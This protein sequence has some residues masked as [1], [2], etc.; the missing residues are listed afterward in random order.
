MFKDHLTGRSGFA[1]RALVLAAA[2][3]FLSPARAGA[4]EAKYPEHPIRLVIGAGP[5]LVP[6][7]IAQKIQEQFGHN[8]FVDQQPGAGGVIAAQ[9]V[10]K[11]KP[12]GYTLLFSTATFVAIQAFRPNSTFDMSRDFEPV[13][14]VGE[15]PAVLFAHPSIGVSNLAELRAYAAKHPGELNCASSG[16]G[17]Q[18]HLGCEILRRFGGMDIVHIP[19]NGIAPAT[20]DLLAGRAQMLFGFLTNMPFVEDGKLVAIAVSSSRRASAAPNIPTGIEAGLPDLDYTTWYGLS[21]PKGTPRAI[22]DQ[23]NAELKAVLSDAF[24]QDR[25]R[26]VGFEPEPSTPDEFG[27]FVAKDLIRW[28]RIVKETGAKPD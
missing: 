2:L 19:Y 26:S 24:V 7:L 4:A 28:T 1:R 20:T 21:A 3:A 17:T 8:V 15:G 11:A 25:I 16:L 12:D 18:A 5:D 13:G 14:K 22:R 27:A 23:L 9:T 6:R 10:A